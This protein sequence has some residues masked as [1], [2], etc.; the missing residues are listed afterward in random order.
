MRARQNPDFG[1]PA[2]RE[3][4]EAP[5]ARE[6]VIKRKPF[7]SDRTEQA[8]YEH[9][10]EANPKGSEEGTLEYLERIVKIATGKLAQR[11]K[12]MPAVEEWDP[13]LP[14]KD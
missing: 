7:W 10:V 2:Y 1:P 11:P 5:D 8:T 14:Y 13:R 4:D 6:W 3:P 9:A 12:S